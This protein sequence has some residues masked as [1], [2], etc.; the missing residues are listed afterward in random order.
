MS[1]ARNLVAAPLRP[2]PARD[3]KSRGRLG[4]RGHL[5]G[6][7]YFDKGAHALSKVALTDVERGYEANDLVVETAGDE[8]HVAL[9]RRGDRCL[10]YR[11]LVELR[12]DHR[13]EPANLAK[14]RM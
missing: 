12:C 13:T 6:A 14:A 2:S 9:E 3:P 5:S 7:R 1:S 4:R 8:E 10:R 11:L